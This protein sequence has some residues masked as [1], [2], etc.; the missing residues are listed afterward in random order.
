MSRFLSCGVVIEFNKMVDSSKWM[1]DYF[2][3]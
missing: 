2:I 3:W 1:L